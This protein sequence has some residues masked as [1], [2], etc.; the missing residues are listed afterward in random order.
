MTKS[1][2]VFMSP[3]DVVLFDILFI[4]RLRTIKVIVTIEE[5]ANFIDAIKNT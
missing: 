1:E 4:K 3:V 2:I 5:V